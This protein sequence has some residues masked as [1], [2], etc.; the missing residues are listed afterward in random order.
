MEVGESIFSTAVREA[1]FSPRPNVDHASPGTGGAAE[2]VVLCSPCCSVMSCDSTMN[3]DGLSC[4]G[5]L[6]GRLLTRGFKGIKSG[7]L[8]TVEEDNAD[9][10]SA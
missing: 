5:T 4:G 2:A 9:G 8:G 6:Y 10:S 7:A 3:N 1:T